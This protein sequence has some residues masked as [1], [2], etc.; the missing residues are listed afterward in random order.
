MGEFLRILKIRKIL[1]VLITVVSF[2]Y[3]FME[4][5]YHGIWD[6]Y[7]QEKYSEDIRNQLIL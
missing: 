5:G 6:L 4:L 1:V 7:L 3:F 2:N